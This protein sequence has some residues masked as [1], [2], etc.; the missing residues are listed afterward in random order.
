MAR[1]ARIVSPSR[2][3]ARKRPQVKV[4]DEMPARLRASADHRLRS[5]P[6]AWAVL[7]VCTRVS[8]EAGLYVRCVC[9]LRWR[10]GSAFIPGL[11]GSAGRRLA[12]IARLDTLRAVKTWNTRS[13]RVDGSPRMGSALRSGDAARPGPGDSRTEAWTYWPSKRIGLGGEPV[14]ARRIEMDQAGRAPTRDGSAWSERGERDQSCPDFTTSFS[15]KTRI[16]SA[17]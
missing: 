2:F 9:R 1:L 8:V 7:G 14:S 15:A 13:G 11:P 3:G 16:P 17:R 5:Q 4:R 12:S 6:L 10:S